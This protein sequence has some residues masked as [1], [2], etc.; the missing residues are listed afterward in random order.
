MQAVVLLKIQVWWYVTL[1][2]WESSYRR[3]EG[4]QCLHRQGQ[5]A[6]AAYIITPHMT[7]D[8]QVLL[9]LENSEW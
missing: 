5:T 4:M 3:F 8:L 1:C 7:W 9:Y 6:V 2:R